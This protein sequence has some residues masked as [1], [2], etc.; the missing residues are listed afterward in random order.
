V[1]ANA[2]ITFL[3]TADLERSRA[4]YERTLGLELVTDQG[5]CHIYRVTKEAFLGVCE[6]E[7][8]SPTEGVIVTLVHDDVD[9][10][11]RQIIAAGGTIDR[12]PDHSAQF[13][14]Y[15]AFLRD[16]DGN[17]LEI[18]SFD[19]PGWSSPLS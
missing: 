14:I 17:L 6:R 9:G 1:I 13:G 19:D 16:P 7:T 5:T 4:F 8:A 3:P 2:Q 11:C 15:H 18:Q 12:G 10:W